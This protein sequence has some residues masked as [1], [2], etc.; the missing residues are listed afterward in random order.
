[1]AEKQYWLIKSEPDVYSIDDL[2]R[3]GRTGWEG[4]R[5]YQARNFMRDGMKVGDLVFFYHSSADPAG[6]AGVA[7]VAGRAYPDPSQFDRK[8]E[9]YDADSDPDQPRWMM[10]DVEFVEK[11]KRLIPLDELRGVKGLE[12]M[13]LLKRGQRL[14]IQPVTPGEWAIIAK[15][16]G[17]KCR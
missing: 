8:S 10:V 9:Y 17:L 16:A 7:K 6:I 11:C 2:A 15:L 3:D 4:V 14:S 13:A 1:M 12:K 5:N